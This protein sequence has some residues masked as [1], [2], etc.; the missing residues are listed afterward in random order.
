MNLRRYSDNGSILDKHGAVVQTTENPKRRTHSDDDVFKR[1]TVHLGHLANVSNTV[2]C[3][4]KKRLLM[5]EVVTS[6]TGD[7]QFREYDNLC[8]VLYGFLGRFLDFSH[9]VFSICHLELGAYCS[10]SVKSESVIHF[11]LAFFG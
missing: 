5:E 6:I 7:T 1:I 2:D 3:L 10:K 11:F 9:V 8:A 4:L